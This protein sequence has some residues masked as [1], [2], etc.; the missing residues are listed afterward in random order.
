MGRASTSDEREEDWKVLVYKT[1]RAV[2]ELLRDSSL[3]TDGTPLLNEAWRA[4]LNRLVEI[5]DARR[6]DSGE[7]DK[8]ERRAPRPCRHD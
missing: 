8:R 6:V 1:Y 4:H 7:V 2:D 5:N 3:R